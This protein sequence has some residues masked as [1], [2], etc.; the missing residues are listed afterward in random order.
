MSHQRSD[1]TEAD[2][3]ATAIGVAVPDLEAA[4]FST[5]H[6]PKANVTIPVRSLVSGKRRMDREMYEALKA[7][8]HR[9]IAFALTAMQPIPPGDRVAVGTEGDPALRAIAR[10]DLTIGGQTRAVAF[11]V[12]IVARDGGLRI[13]GDAAMKMTEFG[14]DPPRLMLGAL[15]VGDAITV[16]FVWEPDRL[17]PE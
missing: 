4:F 6:P 1:R 9:D 17:Q 11:P 12:S 13:Q 10:G 5:N 2:G 7:D 14:I 15:R 8:R 3:D 16:R